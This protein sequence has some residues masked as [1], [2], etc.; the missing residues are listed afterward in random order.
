MSQELSDGEI[1]TGWF[2]SPFLDPASSLDPT[3]RLRRLY[4]VLMRGLTLCFPLGGTEAGGVCDFLL[5]AGLLFSFRCGWVLC[6]EFGGALVGCW[7]RG[8][9]RS[10]RTRS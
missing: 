9:R 10:L 3:Y 2:R 6:L 1:R 8:L 5:R 4:L 7:A